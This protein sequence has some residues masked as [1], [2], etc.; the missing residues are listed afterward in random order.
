MMLF[1]ERVSPSYVQKGGF[2]SV[3]RL[4]GTIGAGFGFFYFYTCSVREF[5]A[6]APSTKLG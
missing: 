6:L 5:T 1:W 4:A 2:A 3:M